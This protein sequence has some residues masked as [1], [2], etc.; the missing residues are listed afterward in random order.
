MDVKQ[1]SDIA[2][3]N[4]NRLTALETILPTLAT[5]LDMQRLIDDLG[6]NRLIMV[7]TALLIATDIL[8]RALG[9]R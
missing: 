3:H 6:W 1:L 7:S 8:A 5:K 9:L 2:Q 4:S